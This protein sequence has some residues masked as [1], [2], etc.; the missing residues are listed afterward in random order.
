MKA[1]LFH[2]P[3]PA[4]VVAS[5]ALIVAMGG[6]SYAAI[7]LPANSVGTKQ[8]KKNAVTGAKVKNGSL[9]AGDFKASSLPRGPQGLQGPQGIQGAQGV[10]GQSSAR[11]VTVRSSAEQSDSAT[12]SCQPGETALGGG[13]TSSDGLLW[14]TGPV[15]ESGTPTQWIAQAV[16][17]DGSTTALVRAWVICGAP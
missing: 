14:D 3:S 10:P 1:K 17:G 2:R 15:Q 6:T 7:K 12:A 8:L 16:Q 13:G 4:M 11:T 9:A 5:I